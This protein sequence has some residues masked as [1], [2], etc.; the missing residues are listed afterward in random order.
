MVFEDKHDEGKKI[1]MTANRK[2]RKLLSAL[3][4][5]VLTSVLLSSCGDNGREKDGKKE[6]TTSEQPAENGT[7]TP[8]VTEETK[9]TETPTPKPTKAPTVTATPT[10]TPSCPPPPTSTPM[11]TPIK[12]YMAEE[13]LN[14]NR[15]L[16][17]VV[18]PKR[19]IAKLGTGPAYSEQDL[20][21]ME[22]GITRNYPITVTDIIFPTHTSDY[23]RASSGYSDRGIQSVHISGLRNQ[24]VQNAINNR[25]DEV[26]KTLANPAYIPNVA[27]VIQVFEE[28]GIPGR[29]TETYAHDAYGY[30]SVEIHLICEWSETRHFPNVHEGV[31]EYGSSVWQYDDYRHFR[32]DW[33]YVYDAGQWGDNYAGKV[34]FRYQLCDGVNLVF[35]LETGEEVMLSDLFPEGED[36]LGLVNDEV[37]KQRDYPY[38]E[39]SY[40][41]YYE[42]KEYDGGK[43]FSG[44]KGDEGFSID[45]YSDDLYLYSETLKD[46]HIAIALPKP[47][48]NIATP[49]T[50]SGKC[51]YSIAPLQRLTGKPIGITGYMPAKAGNFT[52]NTKERGNV[53]ITVY[54]DEVGLFA[55]SSLTGKPEESPY[56]MSRDVVYR[57]TKEWAERHFT[58]ISWYEDANSFILFPAGASVYPNGY[59][60]VHLHVDGPQ[61]DG[62]LI[63]GDSADF[64]MKDGRYIE[65]SEIFDISYEEILKG[66][67]TSGNVMS[68]EQASYCAGILSP[69]ITSI[70]SFA[71]NGTVDLDSIEFVF[72]DATEE[73]KVGEE[74]QQKLVGHF[75]NDTLE[76]F[77]YNS[78][79][80]YYVGRLQG[81]DVLSHLRIYE[82]Y[83]FAR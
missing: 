41:W 11:P 28:N 9:L 5:A 21:D 59:V 70:D 67:F 50:Y 71:Y 66:I 69:Y 22:Y 55:Y 43:L 54:L 2:T 39:G 23:A 18:Y 48:P 17:E 25:I 4:I 49:Q 73:F 64:W 61:W 1:G 20:K 7:P 36:Y 60:C 19:E 34:T 75:P 78:A 80:N 57:A 74:I 62:W 65:E 3:M 53:N 13:V 35:N 81:Y 56:A 6:P 63:G 8:D 68:E 47:V 77:I 15:E 12:D 82:G 27:G 42:A 46:G 24:D 37:A 32:W 16:H 10:V 33:D 30:L 58:P 76:G 40:D 79:Y 83:T 31:G 72:P 26:V 29:Y 44:I 14:M 51:T 45:N 38:W 52:V